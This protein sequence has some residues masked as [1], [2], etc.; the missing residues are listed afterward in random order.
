MTLI[1]VV[2]SGIIIRLVLLYDFPIFLTADSPEYLFI[3]D[4]IYKELN[5]FASGLGDW[6]L[7]VYP[8]FLTLVGLIMPFTSTNVLII[9]KCLT[10]CCI[11]F[12]A[13][14][15]SQLQSRLLMIMLVLS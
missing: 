5:F 3:S 14:I 15:G 11:F 4:K 9:Q 6:R 10:L 1:G 7:P 8:I 13:L 12:G 2:L